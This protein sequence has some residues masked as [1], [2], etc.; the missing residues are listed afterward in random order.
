MNKWTRRKAGQI[1]RQTFIKEVGRTDRLGDEEMIG[2][3]DGW[4]LTRWDRWMDGWMEDWIDGR[5]DGWMDAD[6]RVDRTTDTVQ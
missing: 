3:M 6:R 4:I 5:M 1:D 2:S